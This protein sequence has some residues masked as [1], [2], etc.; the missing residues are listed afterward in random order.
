MLG[1]WNSQ[2]VALPSLLRHFT[3]PGMSWLPLDH[4]WRKPYPC[5]LLPLQVIVDQTFATYGYNEQNPGSSLLWKFVDKAGNPLAAE[6]TVMTKRP[7]PVCNVA[8]FQNFVAAKM[9]VP[10]H[11]PH[12][13]PTR[14]PASA[15]RH[16]QKS[17]ATLCSALPPLL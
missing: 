9:Q 6:E 11:A 4:T 15:L 1:R 8:L 7:D 3:V 12:R 14:L 10:H 2:G 13:A 5:P 16:Q 17:H